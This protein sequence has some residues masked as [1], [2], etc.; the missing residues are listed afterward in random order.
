MREV[1]GSTPV[2]NNTV[3]H[4]ALPFMSVHWGWILGAEDVGCPTC[5]NVPLLAIPMILMIFECLFINHFLSLSW[6]STDHITQHHSHEKKLTAIFS[7]SEGRTPRDH[8]KIKCHH[9]QS[10]YIGQRF[11]C[12]KRD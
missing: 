6:S 1:A 2:L 12:N 11:W 9:S 5:V 3:Q 8:D 4:Q 10:L 7:V